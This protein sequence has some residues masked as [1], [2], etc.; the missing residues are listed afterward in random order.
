MNPPFS[1]SS[2]AT[3]CYHP[4]PSLSNPSVTKSDQFFLPNVSWNSSVSI[5]TAT[6]LVYI[7]LL[8]L[9]YDYSTFFIWFPCLWY[10][11]LQSII[12]TDAR[13]FSFSLFLSL[14]TYFERDREREREERKEESQ[15]EREREREK[16][17]IPSKLHAASREP[18]MGLKLTNCEIM[19]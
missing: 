6:A 2:K 5:S 15:R 16:D 13:Y 9:C 19:T 18:N 7:F 3:K 14:F 10:S 1:E 4:F 8:S 12:Y 17:R 11:S